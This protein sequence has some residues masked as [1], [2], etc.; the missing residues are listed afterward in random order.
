MSYKS[1]FTVK[2]AEI[3]VRFK[4][5]SIV[6]IPEKFAGFLCEDNKQPDEEYE[7]QLLNQPLC[8]EEPPIT[9]YNGMKIYRHNKQWIRVYSQLVAEDGCQVACSSKKNGKRVL[10]Y[11]ASK[12]EFYSKEL[13]FL[14]LIGIEEV[15][16]KQQAMMLHSSVVLLNDQT[17][18]F[19][20][21]SGAGKSTQASL[22]REFL[23]AE[24]INGD[25]CIIRKIEEV[26]YGCGSLWSGT[27]GIYR[28]ENA[29]IKGIF[30]LKQSEENTVRRVHAEAFA[31]IYSQCVVNAWD[32]GFIEKMTDLIVELLEQVPVY[33]LSCR[34]DEDAVHIAYK[35]LFEEGC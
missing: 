12:W 20:G 18:L 14:H 34:P 28:Q 1:V 4:F 6:K 23:D 17:V 9:S 24:V 16:L 22:W 33:E 35:I 25:R 7:I 5:P 21:P 30:L 15:L 29:P 3:S 8:F 13:H 31:K 26:F 27:S 2:F 19:S 32:S 11:P 10:Y